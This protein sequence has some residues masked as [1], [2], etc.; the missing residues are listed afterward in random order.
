MQ[1]ST[2]LPLKLSYTDYLRFRDLV[3]ERS[4]LHFPDKKRSELE[5]GL[6]KALTDSP[7]VTA[8]DNL[9]DYYHILSDRDNPLGRVE[10]ERL[11][12][13]LTIG[14][15]HFFRNQAQFNALT[16]HVLP[17]LIKRK[18]AAATALGLQP[19]LRVWSTG[20]ASGEEPYSLAMLLRQL[21]PD[22]QQWAV[23]ILATD[24]NQQSLTFAQ[25]GV[26]SDWSFREARAK[27]SQARY[28]SKETTS[29]GVRRYRLHDEIKQMVTF[30]SLNLIED[31]YP[32]IYNNTVSMDLILCRNVT[33]YFTEET[34]QQ[35]VDRFYRS[36]A[37]D[38]WLVVG[39]S[40]PSL[41]I[42][43]KFKTRNYP[44]TL[45]YQRT[46]QPQSAWPLAADQPIVQVD[47]PPSNNVPIAQN[48]HRSNQLAA[49]S[50]P[51]SF[52][53]AQTLLD[54]G[55]TEEA[56]AK[57]HQLLVK[58][59]ESAAGCSLL[60][61]AY[62][63][64]GRWA[65]ARHWCD[66]ALKLDTLQADAYY[67]IALINEQESRLTQAVNMLKKAIYL[68]RDKPLYH[69]NQ[70]ILY[71]KLGQPKSARRASEN[72]IR[73]LE[74]WSPDTIIPDTGGTTAYRLLETAQKIRDGLDILEGTNRDSINPT[75][76]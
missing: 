71:K 15:T 26:Y 10:M 27:V 69:F 70:A 12:N 63:N 62:A 40:E 73:L 32:A 11:I 60:G 22:I 20:C 57:L 23:L 47:T 38:G 56:I 16:L 25:E 18:R 24:I 35:V 34:T 13:A 29:S 41:E 61:R 76:P 55:D 17:E 9:D 45:F 72:A 67:V 21:L 33:I 48:R 36:L 59:P 51:D 74:K 28:F 4:G 8:T 1:T 44:N 75:A 3:L 7:M 19:Q 39:H 14:E 5:N 6:N 68:E 52:A 31:E 30:A 43:R 37:I 50:Q 66:C 53:V 46:A 2:S 64:L 58:K 54:Q 65:E 42:Y 49:S